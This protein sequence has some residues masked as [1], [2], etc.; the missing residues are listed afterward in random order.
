MS[1]VQLCRQKNRPPLSR[2]RLNLHWSHAVHPSGRPQEIGS[3]CSGEM[4]SCPKTPRHRQQVACRGRSIPST[5]LG[6]AF[7]AA[8]V[9]LAHLM[10]RGSGSPNS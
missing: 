1:R 10:S 2:T 8:N 3:G 9:S 6:N 4:C 7:A 5:V